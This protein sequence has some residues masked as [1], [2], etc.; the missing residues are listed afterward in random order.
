MALQILDDLPSL[1]L[2]RL[3][4]GGMPPRRDPFE[5]VAKKGPSPASARG[6]CNTVA[7]RQRCGDHA[8]AA[9]YTGACPSSWP[10]LIARRGTRRPPSRS[11]RAASMDGEKHQVLLGVTGSGKTFTMAKLIEKLGRPAL[12]LAH[13][14]TLAA[15]LYHE[16][17]TFF[18]A[19]R[20]GVFRQLLRLL[21]AGSLHPVER[22]LHRERSH[23]QRRTGPAAAF[24]H[25]VAVRAPRLRDRRQR[26]L[27]LRS[28]LARGLLRHAADAGKGPEDHAQ[29]DHC[30]SWSRSSTTATITISGAGRFACAA[31]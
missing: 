30:R 17:K 1:G 15:Q 19:Q 13:N 12:V 21:P 18:P 11:F 23:H 2:R 16:F 7:Q 10:L 28:R 9:D 6:S 27:H 25:E 3:A 8:R 4:T 5:W 22:R 29:G 24:R 26:Q 14:K 20:R 31:T